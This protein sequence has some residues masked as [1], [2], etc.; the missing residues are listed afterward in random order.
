M[1]IKVV[2]NIPK[3]EELLVTCMRVSDTQ[4]YPSVRGSIVEGSE[5]THCTQCK[6]NV[7]IS[8]ETKESI[9]DV[10]KAKIVCIQC[11]S[12]IIKNSK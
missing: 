4:D 1:K 7:Y 8:P 3:D 12:N 6:R 5:I 10:K 11:L 2:K 9:K